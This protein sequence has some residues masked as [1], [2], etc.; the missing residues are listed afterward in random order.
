MTSKTEQIT[1]KY[2]KEIVR[3]LQTLD[4][5]CLTIKD[6][7]LSYTYNKKYCDI[8]D[9]LLNRKIIGHRSRYN[10]EYDTTYVTVYI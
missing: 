9:E 5:F 8:Y 7:D 4:D 10:P 6:G 2:V 3:D 1:Y